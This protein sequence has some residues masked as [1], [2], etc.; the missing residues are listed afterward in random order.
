MPLPKVHFVYGHVRLSIARYRRIYDRDPRQ[1][2]VGL[3]D[4]ASLEQKYGRRLPGEPMHIDGIPV[5]VGSL[6]DTARCVG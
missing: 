5:A 1:V 4:M 6:E 3:M 2:L